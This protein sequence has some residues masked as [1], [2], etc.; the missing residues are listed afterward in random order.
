MR[1]AAALDTLILHMLASILS[2]STSFRA[3]PMLIV[4]FTGVSPFMV[5]LSRFRAG[6]GDSPSGKRSPVSSP[7]QGLF[8]LSLP[9]FSNSP[10]GWCLYIYRL[11]PVADTRLCVYGQAVLRGEFGAV[12]YWALWGVS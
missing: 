8:A 6:N 7:C 11:L 3:C 9:P 12:F 2:C 1:S 4:L 10:L 5:L